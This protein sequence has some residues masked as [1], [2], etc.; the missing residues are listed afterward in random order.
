MSFHQPQGF[1]TRALLEQTRTESSSILDEPIHETRKRG[2][3]LTSPRSIINQPSTS[4]MK[5]SRAFSG[6]FDMSDFLKVS[7]QVEDSIVFPSIEWPTLTDDTE[8]DEAENDSDDDFCTFSSRPNKR[9]CRGLVRCNRSSNL[10]SLI[11]MASH[12]TP[13]RRGSSG[14]LS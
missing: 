8:D 9:H 2:E 4:S 3:A 5:R 10:S 6:S 12:H 1:A 14:S 13:E 7:Q 11:D